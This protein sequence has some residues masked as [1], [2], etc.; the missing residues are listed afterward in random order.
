MT[1][2][3]HQQQLR[4]GCRSR[5]DLLTDFPAKDGTLQPTT[6]ARKPKML[7]LSRK[8][9]ESVIVDGDTAVTVTWVRDGNAEVRVSSADALSFI[10]VLSHGRS[11]A[12]KQDVRLTLNGTHG[13]QAR[14]GFTAPKH[15]TIHR[16][17]IQ[18][19]VD[20]EGSKAVAE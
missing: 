4:T 18:A 17:E 3:F 12:I 15:I 14:L 10:C 7:L 11:V 8:R 13:A 2:R 19:R 5:P 6:N 1:S 9:G 20:R 16:E